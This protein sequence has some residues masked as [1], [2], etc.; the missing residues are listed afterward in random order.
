MLPVYEKLSMK[1]VKDE[2]TD[3][4]KYAEVLEGLSPAFFKT[5]AL[6]LRGCYD[7]LSTMFNVAK[8][9]IYTAFEML[10]QYDP[11]KAQEIMQ[12]EENIDMLTDRVSKYLVALSPNIQ[13]GYQV[14]ILDQYYKIV[15]E[16]E[17]LGDH[18]VNICETAEKMDSKGL[19]FSETAKQELKVLEELIKRILDY[20]EV[21]FKKRDA[22][23]AY[24]IEPL[25]EVVDDLVNS[26]KEKHI[27]RLREG[28]C[29]IEADSH[30]LN[31]LTDIERI[32][33]I[34]S[35]IGVSTVARVYPERA[36]QAH[37]YISSLHS[38]NNET[39]NAE[40]KSAHEEFFGKLPTE[41]AGQIPAEATPAG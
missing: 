10:G 13:I 23:A 7:A 20:S 19:A 15:T 39:F 5:P 24:H 36:A 26:M 14:Q 28:K 35:N 12:D 27:V 6:A 34:C 29:N 38:G 18:A 32:S 8:K 33:D 11:K 1:I 41:E 31:M 2:K 21:A 17:R 4:G 22:E 3:D 30:F 9:N 25:E 37:D 40:Y 16:F